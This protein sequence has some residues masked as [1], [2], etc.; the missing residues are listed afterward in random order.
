LTPTDHAAPHRRIDDIEVLR[1]VAI[2]MVLVEHLPLNL[3]YWRGGMMIFMDEYW[4]G[5]AGVDLFFVIS[6]Y[7][8]ARSLLPRLD[9]ARQRGAR[10]VAVVGFWL[11]RAW[12]LLPAAWL[13]L[14]VPL[15]L[16]AWCNHFHSFRSL[17]A[18]IVMGVAG[19]FNVADFYIGAILGR[20]EPGVDSSYWSLSLEEQFYAVFPLLCLWLRR[21]LPYLMLAL[22]AYGFVINY[23]N[24]MLGITRPN[25]LAM[26]VAIA[27][28]RARA[29]SQRMEPKF[30]ARSGLLRAVVLA[31]YVAAAGA[32]VAAW[33]APVKSPGWGMLA[34]ISG[35]L[36]FAASFDRG[37]VM[38]AGRVQRALIWV[39]ARSYSYYLVHMTAY[40]AA[41]EIDFWLWPPNFVHT[42]GE[43][44]RLV[45]LAAPFLLVAG[46]LTYRWVER[47]CRRHGAL[48]AARYEAA[49]GALA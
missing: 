40:G 45:G 7:V 14:V 43:M 28:F 44:A 17:H 21:P 24:N 41:R 20:V 37:Y 15:P 9:A 34:I 30:L 19:L 4:R 1:G 13:W 42:Y 10:R 46:E 12:R 16:A 18:N 49:H 23:D 31:V 8:I 32:L 38:R 5:A 48:V 22:V 35:L 36:V 25:G 39:G 26:G 27:L 11:R 47:P 2:L 6:G 3:I 29:G 33:A